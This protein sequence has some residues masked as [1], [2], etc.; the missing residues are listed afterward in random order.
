MALSITITTTDD[1]AAS[2]RLQR[3]IDRVNALAGSDEPEVEGHAMELTIGSLGTDSIA[4][5]TAWRDGCWGFSDRGCGWYQIGDH[6]C[7]GYTAPKR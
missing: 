7:I 6:S 1:F 2:P 5:T 4:G 3:A